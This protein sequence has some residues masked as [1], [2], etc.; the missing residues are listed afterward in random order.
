MPAFHTPEPVTAVVEIVSGA[1]HLA[2]TDRD[3][4]IVDIAPRDPERASDV[5]A[6]EQARIDFHNGTLVVT[7]GKK[8]L[9]LAALPVTPT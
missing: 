5:R 6:A 2:A 8:V 7:A 3:D 4:T 9:S 1:V